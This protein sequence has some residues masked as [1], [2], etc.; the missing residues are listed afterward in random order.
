[1]AHNLIT[2]RQQPSLRNIIEAIPEEDWKPIPYWMDG[3]AD[4]A[5]TNYTPFS[6]EP[7]A[8]PVRLIVHRVK[9]TPDTQLALIANYSYHAC[10]TDR[11]G[12]TLELE[13]DH[14]RHAEIENAIRD[15]KYGVGLNHLSSGRFSANG[16]WLAVQSLPRTRYGV[17]A[18]NLARW[19][20][21]IALGEPVSTTKTL[22]GRFSLAG[23]IPARP[24]A[25]PCTFPRTG[26]TAC[27]DALFLTRV[28]GMG[29]STEPPN[30]LADLRQAGLRR[31]LTP[32]CTPVSSVAD[33]A[34]G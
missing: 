5:E 32:M 27:P 9:P 31:S 33:A 3:G 34:A 16:A 15:L 13:T 19:T 6:S 29:R 25:S 10:I 4:V 1:M 12:D 23:R 20:T 30:C 26:P 24:A 8:I 2:A 7:D 22:R 11:E 14:H 28:H 17:M 21:R 18:H